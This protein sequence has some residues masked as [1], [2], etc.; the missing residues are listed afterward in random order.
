MNLDEILAAKLTTAISGAERWSDLADALR[1]PTNPQEDDP[2]SAAIIAFDYVLHAGP[3]AQEREQWGEF[4]PAVS[5]QGHAYPPP[6]KTIPDPTLS[7]WARLA[8][9]IKHPI[10]SSRLNDLLWTRKWKPKPHERARVAISSYLDLG[11]SDWHPI[12]RAECLARALELTLALN[13]Q[14]GAA[15]A[16]TQIISA[17]WEALAQEKPVP[18]VTLRLIETLTP[19][20]SMAPPAD[21]D[22]LLQRAAQKYGA[23]PHLFES[24]KDL[25][26]NWARKT[27]DKAIRAARDKA[28]RWRDVA[29]ASSGLQRH[30]FLQKALE[31]ARQH[32]F[33]DLVATA[34]AELQNMRPESLGLHVHEFSVEFPQEALDWLLGHMSGGADWRECLR[35]FG[36]HGPP[37][38]TPE[39]NIATAQKLMRDYPLQFM[40][41]R[42]VLDS[43]GRPIRRVSTP[44]EHLEAGV[45]DLETRQIHLWGH[46]APLCLKSIFDKHQRPSPEEATVFFTTD[47]IS[48]EIAE[49]ISRSLLLYLDNQFDDALHVLIPRLE[50]IIRDLC[51]IIG[52]VIIREPDGAKTGGVVALGELM[53]QLQGN[54]PEPWRRYL[55]NLLNEP[56]GLNLR[57]RVCH[58]LLARGGPS[59][60]ALALHAA[61]FLRLL[62]HRQRSSSNQATQEPPS[63]G[64][65]SQEPASGPR[66]ES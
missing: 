44:E 65:G 15:R 28:E 24:I 11:K 29:L 12:L 36:G 63:G 59:E 49:R 60:A 6:L 23:D 34:R 2:A 50:T 30:V 18:G 39:E 33:R 3:R 51:I 41:E 25:E 26:A 4:G 55:R 19:A 40:A 10:V 35:R 37:T 27:P 54:F 66:S 58:G 64:S 45:I 47:I 62:N 20:S 61:C 52:A 13:D 56:I 43:E 14:E 9:T 31:V 38:D 8:D 32:G 53:S 1:R 22:S 21:I 17:A 7:Q 46:L 5:T 48:K 42:F 16:V 57:N